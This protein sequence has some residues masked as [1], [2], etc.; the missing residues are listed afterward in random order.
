MRRCQL[1]PPPLYHH[2]RLLH[3]N[4]PIPTIFDYVLQVSGNLP[5]LTITCLLIDDQDDI[6]LHVTP[7]AVKHNKGGGVDTTAFTLAMRAAKIDGG[8]DVVVGGEFNIWIEQD[9]DPQGKR[10]FD[11]NERPGEWVVERQLRGKHVWDRDWDKFPESRGLRGS[12]MQCGFCDRSWSRTL[13]YFDFQLCG[14]PS[15]SF[16]L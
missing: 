10:A 8:L 16:D 1:Y 11:M 14:F 5:S 13:F 3:R 15:R 12:M 6:H 4:V 7:T 2:S 9:W